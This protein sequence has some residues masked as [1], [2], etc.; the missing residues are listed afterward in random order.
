M[1][2]INYKKKECLN[3]VFIKILAQKKSSC[4]SKKMQKEIGRYYSSI[5]SKNK[6]SK[7]NQKHVLSKQKVFFCKKIKEKARN[8]I[9]SL[10]K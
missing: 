8:K 3:C 5:F 6:R 4:Y 7:V 9:I 10:I 2:K 1:F